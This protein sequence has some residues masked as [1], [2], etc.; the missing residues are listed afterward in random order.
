[1][2]I[3]VHQAEKLSL[4]GIGRFVEASKEVRFEG[5]KREQVYNWVECVLLQQ[6][7]AQQGKAARG[8]LRRYI[9]RMTGR[10]RAQS[11]D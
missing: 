7:Y 9:A 4:E 8:L 5:Q 10:S 11:G 2:N 6:E 1:M 3:S